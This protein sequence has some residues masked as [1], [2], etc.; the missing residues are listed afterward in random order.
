MVIFHI[1][2]QCNNAIE[3][4]KLVKFGS[5]SLKKG[6]QIPEFKSGDISSS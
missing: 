6:P 5:D 4:W 2:K 1:Q 3:K